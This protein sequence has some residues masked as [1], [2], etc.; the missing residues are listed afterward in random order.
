MTPLFLKSL[1]I[2]F[3]VGMTIGP[4]AMIGIRN[5]IAHGFFACFAVG[6]GATLADIFYGFLAG[7]GLSF[8]T[9][10]L[11]DYQQIIKI[12][13][14]VMLFYMG[15]K[16]IMNAKK[17]P[18]E[19]AFSSK[20]IFK[21]IIFIFFLTMKNPMTIMFFI[22]VFSSIGGTNFT[23]KEIITIMM[24][25]GIAGIIWWLTLSSIVTIVRKKISQI[26]ITRLKIVSGFIL[27]GFSL[28]N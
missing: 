6:I 1:I 14:S 9:K 20:K 22:G 16:E 15:V 2:G 11:L 4:I 17:I 26:W 24:G 5:G 7:G 23:T 3:S 10:F 25:I 8:I 19:I 27:I 13:G 28:W 21:T 12:T 18:K